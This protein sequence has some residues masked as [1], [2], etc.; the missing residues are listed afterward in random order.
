M[1]VIFSKIEANNTGEAV[2]T[3]SIFNTEIW[4]KNSIS[5]SCLSRKS[6]SYILFSRA[7]KT[8]VLL[9]LNSLKDK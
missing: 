7:F 1:V 6:F 2:A 4:E 9:C 3:T 8:I 5:L